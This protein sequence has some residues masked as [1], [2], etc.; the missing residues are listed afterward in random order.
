[1]LFVFL[2]EKGRKG[3]YL[4]EWRNGEDMGRVKGGETITR[5]YCMK[6]KSIFNKNFYKI[7]TKTLVY[8][9]IQRS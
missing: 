4:A 5:I 7:K 6:T 3:V 8:I 1:M 2:R 9:H